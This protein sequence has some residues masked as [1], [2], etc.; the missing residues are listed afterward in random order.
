M[1]VA[2]REM[3]RS[4]LKFGLLA[5]AVGLLLFLLMFLNTLSRT[6]LSSYVGAIENTSADLIVFSAD[7]QRN[8]QASRFDG[9]AVSVVDGLPGI[10][11]A[12][13]ISEATLTVQ[14]GDRRDDLSLWG[15]A[16]GAPGDVPIVEGRAAGPGEVVMDRSAADLGFTIGST[17]TLIETGRTLEVVGYT[18]DRQYSV[19]PTGYT[20]SSEWAEVFF[21]TYPG[22]PSAPI[23]I[24]A[25]DLEQGS[26]PTAVSADISR[27]LAS[28]DVASPAEAAG[29]APGVSSIETSFNLIVGITFG[30]VIVVI[31]F[32]FTI[33]AVQKQSTFALLRAVGASRTHVAMSIA[34][35]IG[36]TIVAGAALA[37]AVLSLAGL[38][39]SASFP[40]SIDLSAALATAAI[41]LISSL[42]AGLFAIRRALRIDPV[43]A[44]QG[45]A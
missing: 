40:L 27:S 31:G 34:V 9:E 29:S 7:A 1:F 26:D 17:I 3:W 4:K 2:L 16:P 39:S 32:F 11:S 14:V 42:I 12:S 10:R 37:I 6:L 30:I 25:V 18:A 24:I 33:L 43:A 21:A 38:G 15:V 13:G 8:I 23:S 45:V 41:V 19:I 22:V 28:S 44:A 5:V 20:A 35:Q 36:F